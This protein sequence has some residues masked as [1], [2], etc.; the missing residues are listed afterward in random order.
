MLHVL[1]GIIV[2]VI[3]FLMTKNSTTG[4]FAG[5]LFSIS[6][7]HSQVLPAVA[8]ISGRTDPIVA[9]FYLFAFMMFLIFIHYKS[10][11]SYFLSLITFMLALLSKEMAVTLPIVILLYKFMNSDIDHKKESISINF[12]HLYY[13]FKWNYFIFYRRYVIFQWFK[14]FWLR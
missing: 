9:S 3:A 7:I 6:P 14:L 13:I 10:Y 12:E 4:L 2:Y 11:I 1:N 8:W 5:L